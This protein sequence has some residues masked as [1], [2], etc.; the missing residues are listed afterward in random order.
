L[1]L[2]H[3]NIQKHKQKINFKPK[4]VQILGKQHFGRNAKHA[5]LVCMI[6]VMHG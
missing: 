4:K 2:A 5:L 1:I 3:Q 6:I